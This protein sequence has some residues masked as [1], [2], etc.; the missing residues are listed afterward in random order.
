[1]ASTEDLIPP[2]DVTT[3]TQ[4]QAWDYLQDLSEILNCAPQLELD[5]PEDYAM[6]KDQIA[7]AKAY[8]ATFPE[9]I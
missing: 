6:Y 8:L 4:R 1:M 9:Q 2:L 3:L 5:E 7:A